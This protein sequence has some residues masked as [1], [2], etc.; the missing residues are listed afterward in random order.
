MTKTAQD[1]APCF[2][3]SEYSEKDRLELQSIKIGVSRTHAAIVRDA[4][5]IGEELQ[6]ART[7]VRH[8]SYESF[9]RECGLEVE[10]ARGYVTIAAFAAAHGQ[11]VAAKLGI[12]RCKLLSTAAVAAEL[13]KRVTEEVHAGQAPGMEQL[14]SRI[15][16]AGRKAA[17]SRT[18]DLMDDRQDLEALALQLND[19]LEADLLGQLAVFLAQE[20]PGRLRALGDLLGYADVEVATRPAVH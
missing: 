10:T 16:S 17:H 2:D 13:V 12:A 6:R 3:F 9:V 19:A 14:K 18:R 5:R 4:I 1:I 15:A 11:E 8:G 20:R 7:I